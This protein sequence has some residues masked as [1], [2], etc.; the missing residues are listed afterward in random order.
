V[1][2]LGAFILFAA[3]TWMM[4][5]G[6]SAEGAIDIRSSIVSGSLKTGS[7]GL[8]IA[9]LSFIVIA[10]VL[11]PPMRRHPNTGASQ[12]PRHSKFR[13]MV[14]VFWALFCGTA[15]SGVA[16]ATMGGDARTALGVL[17]GGLGFLLLI[18]VISMMVYLDD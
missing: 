17:A 5:V 6:V 4:V 18:W 7:A 15:G 10:F 11:A 16:A 12:V 14:P 9:F 8:F 13:L 3:G 2:L 1:A